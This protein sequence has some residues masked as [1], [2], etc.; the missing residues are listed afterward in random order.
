LSASS[1][2]VKDLRAEA[3]ALKELVAEKPC[4]AMRALTM[5]LARGDVRAFRS[6]NKRS[7][8]VDEIANARMGKNRR[9]RWLRRGA[10]CVAA[11]RVAVLVGRLT[12]CGRK[13]AA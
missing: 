1:G 9:M 6:N 7:L 10:H 11:T 2:T 4:L 5:E 12:I 8:C 3:V 13:H